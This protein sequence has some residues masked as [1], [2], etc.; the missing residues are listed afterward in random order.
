MNQV[1]RNFNNVGMNWNND[2]FI[3]YRTDFRIK[4]ITSRPI[5]S[6]TISELE[7]Y[8]VI[9]LAVPALLFRCPHHVFS[10]GGTCLP[11]LCIWAP[12]CFWLLSLSLKEWILISLLEMSFITCLH[13]SISGKHWHPYV[14]HR[15][16]GLLVEVRLLVG[17]CCFISQ[18][19]NHSGIYVIN[20][21]L[22]YEEKGRQITGE[23]Y[24]FFVPLTWEHSF[25]NKYL[26]KSFLTKTTSHL[27]IQIYTVEFEKFKCVIL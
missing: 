12:G 1:K 13:M 5:Y 17:K 20:C 15:A 14:A 6:V 19:A 11:G 4:Q 23:I 27:G 25:K 22:Q 9:D 7:T 24:H 2:V 26:L 18:T 8:T 21:L 3:N 10:L 16:Q